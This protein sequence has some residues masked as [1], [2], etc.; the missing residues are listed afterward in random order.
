MGF[1]A[2]QESY[3]DAATPEDTHDSDDSTDDGGLSTTSYDDPRVDSGYVP[4]EQEPGSDS[5]E[6]DNE[7]TEETDADDTFTDPEQV[8]DAGASGDVYTDPSEINDSDDSGGSG[9]GGLDSGGSSDS[10][11]SNDSGGSD[12]SDSDGSEYGD[13]DPRLEDPYMP[14]EQTPDDWLFNPNDDG[15]VTDVHGIVGEAGEYLEQTEFV[16]RF[17]EMQEEG[18]IPTNIEDVDEQVQQAREEIEDALD[19]LGDDSIESG[20]GSFDT[21]STGTW[22]VLAV[23]LTGAGGLAYQ[24]GWL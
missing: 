4:D 15:T 10:G 5:W 3:L 22:V 9:D 14:D 1:S 12:G 13:D 8:N 11:D 21:L 24:Q 2:D 16:D 23:A 6:S 18:T 17:E 19:Q 20:T 7:T